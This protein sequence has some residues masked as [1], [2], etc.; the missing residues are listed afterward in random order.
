[1]EKKING[2]YLRLL[3]GDIT[4]QQV[5][6]IVNAANNALAGGGG[7]DGA[8]HR[9]GG[10]AIMAECQAIRR[11]RGPLPTGEAVIT[12]GGMLPAPFV[13]HTVGPIWQ[14]GKKGEA[15]LLARAYRSSLQ[16]AVAKGIKTIAF[17][18]IS[19]GA[20]GYPIAEAAR[21][22]WAQW[23]NFLQ[24]IPAACRKS[25]LYY[26]ANATIWYISRLCR[27][28]CHEFLSAGRGKLR[29]ETGD[30]HG[31]KGNTGPFGAKN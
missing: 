2:C 7:V 19:T 5:E 13:I 12:G 6:A 28:C 31:G 20:Y 26:S 30:G 24:P 21:I 1:M 16:L 17:P 27:S 22:A 9:A 11:E 4:K 8:I 14:G 18:S 23:A 3:Q 29:G 10:P 25:G 15:E